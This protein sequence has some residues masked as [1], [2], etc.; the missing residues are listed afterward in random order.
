MV[1][2]ILLIAAGIFLT[3]M[4]LRR[5]SAK[6]SSDEPFDPGST[7]NQIKESGEIVPPQDGRQR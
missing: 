7:S 6:A 2:T 3:Y 5:L 4:L 1:L